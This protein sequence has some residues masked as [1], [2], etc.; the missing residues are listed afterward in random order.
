[1]INRQ[2]LVAAIHDTPMAL[3]LAV[4]G[5]GVAVIGDLLGVPGASRTVLEASVPYAELALAELIGE[6]PDQAVSQQ[7]ARLMAGACLERAQ[8]LGTEPVAG[9]A[10]TAALVTD[11]EKKG[12]HRAHV[13][14]ATVDGTKSWSLTLEKGAKDRA[15]EDR[16]V[17]DLILR[18]IAATA[19]IELSAVDVEDV[20]V[21]DRAG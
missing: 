6:T 8:F 5:G 17:S 15:G 19:G 10:C 12:D 16:I 7:T 18:S 1:M 3:A 11:R 2:D 20:D 4:T 14:I 21:E 9:V 13:A